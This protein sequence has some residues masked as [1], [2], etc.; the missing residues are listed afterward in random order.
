MLNTK[1]KKKIQ[2]INSNKLSTCLLCWLCVLDLKLGD[3]HLVRVDDQESRKDA[4]RD[5]VSSISSIL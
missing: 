5:Y 3:A 2:A 1:K 4:G